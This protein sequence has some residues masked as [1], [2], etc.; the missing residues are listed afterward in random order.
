MSIPDFNESNEGL[1]AAE[2]KVIANLKKAILLTAGA[3]VQKLMM[4]IS[5]EQEILMD[6]ADM[7]IELFVSE[8][9]LLRVE[10]MIKANGEAASA[11]YLDILRT[12]M[13]DACERAFVSGKHAVTAFTEGD[14][15]RM[16]LLGIKRF[17]KMDSFNT[18]DARRRIVAKMLEKNSGIF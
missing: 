16:L 5:T 4:K 2:K 3:A 17:T 9:L 15:Q 10:K 6:C 7:M 18:K 14:E 8:S 1:L 11:V 12:Y 13:S